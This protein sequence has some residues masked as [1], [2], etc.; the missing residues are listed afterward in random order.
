MPILLAVLG[1][2]ITEKSG[3]LNL[4]LEGI[5]LM[6]ALAGFMTA[7]HLEQAQVGS[8]LAAWWGLLAGA[9]AGMAM[10]LIVAVLA[11]TLRADQVVSSVMVVLLGQG[12]SSYLYRQQ[13]SSLTARIEGLPPAPIPVLADL[14][15]LGPLLFNHDLSVYLAGLLVPATWFLLHQTTLG[16]NIR[17][18]GENPS[19]V[20]SSGVSVGQIRYIATLLGAGLA[21]LGGAVLTVAQLHLFR[22]EITAGR[23]WIAVALV[24]FARWRPGLALAGALLFGVADALQFRIQALSGAT[25]AIPY[26]V[27][28]MLPYVLTIAVLLRGMHSQDRPERLGMPYVRG[29]R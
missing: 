9:G 2:I 28:L 19:A 29:E 7:W 3:V 8:T 18:V 21:G 10:G 12:L 23:G 11:V 17:A 25:T 13:F 1:E 5:M 24:I 26:E 27:L 6:G 15:V 14:P 16:L 22:E 20:E 4:G